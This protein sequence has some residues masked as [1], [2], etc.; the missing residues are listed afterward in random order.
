MLGGL[1][2]YGFYALVA[3]FVFFI[4]GPAYTQAW[5]THKLIAQIAK[6]RSGTAMPT[7]AEVRKEY[8]SRA[9]AAGAFADADIGV[10]RDA[11]ELIIETSF[12]IDRR[13][14]ACCYFEFDFELASNRP[15]FKSMFGRE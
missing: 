12:S 5:K 2:K 6:E 11:G 9:A 3:Y 4:A 15:A 7:P 14:S 10:L 13:I 1:F 8:A